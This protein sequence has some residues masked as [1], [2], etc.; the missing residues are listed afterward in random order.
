[1]SLEK[2]KRIKRQLE[3]AEAVVARLTAEYRAAMSERVQEVKSEEAA[4]RVAVTLDP[5]IV[6][7]A[8]MLKRL[9]E[10]AYTKAVKIQREAH[11]HGIPHRGWRF[12]P[13][14][15]CHS[16]GRVISAQQFAFAR[17]CG[18]CD[19]GNSRTARLHCFDPRWFVLGR[20]VDER[21]GES[22]EIDPVFVPASEAVDYPTTY[23]EPRKPSPPP[24][25]KPRLPPTHGKRWRP[26]FIR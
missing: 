26:S 4:E 15:A 1:M 13:P 8:E 3:Q 24:R 23:R 20:V 5:L 10:T 9:S 7:D 18:G 21:N 16:C 2:L 19:V 14:Y 17:G 25:Q 6:P 12:F 22:L 11:E